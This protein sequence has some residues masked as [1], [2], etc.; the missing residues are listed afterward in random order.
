MRLKDLHLLPK[1]RDCVSYLYVEHAKVE[2]DAR[3]IALWDAQG[4]VPV[5]CAGLGV[6]MLGPACASK[7]SCASTACAS[8]SPWTNP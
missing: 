3:A 8:R 2:Q 5:P 4:R 6:L 1:F 7:W